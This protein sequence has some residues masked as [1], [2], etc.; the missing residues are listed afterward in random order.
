MTNS[1][2]PPALL[3]SIADVERD[4]GLSKDTLR[5]WE[6]RYGFP[7]PVRDA[8]GER[9]YDDLQLQR[10]RRIRRLLDAGH[11]PGRV[12]PLSDEAL[13]ALDT[14]ADEQRIQSPFPTDA[15]VEAPAT[16]GLPAAD[17]PLVEWM[18]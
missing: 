9:Q 14:Q 16:S 7:T 13:H 5:V 12:V 8:V 11:R 17:F 2:S 18:R 10:L 1:I 15:A 4:T 6:R 3:H